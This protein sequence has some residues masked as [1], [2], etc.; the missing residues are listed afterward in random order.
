M[1]HYGV[2]V[3]SNNPH[4]INW[5]AVHSY[6][7][8]LGGGAQPFAIVKINQGNGY[9]NPDAATD[10]AQARAAGFAV[11]GYN[12][13]QGD[14]DAS[15]QQVAYTRVAAGIPETFDVELPNGAST[16]AYIAQTAQFV[17]MAPGALVY[18][19]QAEVQEGFPQGSGL[20]LA[21][22]NNDPAHAAYACTIHQ[23]QNQGTIPGCAGIFDLNVWTDTEARFSEFFHLSPSVA[24]PKP[25]YTLNA[26]LLS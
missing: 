10:I 12:M 13:T 26:L 4:P 11:A 19:N 21:H 1:A 7:S 18:L 23:Y 2:D 16:Q 25:P 15:S 6:L 24:K 5:T 3:S 22:Y 9:V 14:Q 20:W 8:E 17:Q